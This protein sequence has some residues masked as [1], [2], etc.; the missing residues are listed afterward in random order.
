MVDGGLLNVGQYVLHPAAEYVLRHLLSLACG[1][2]SRLRGFLKAIV[3]ES[4]D[5]DNRTSHLAGE[6]VQIEFVPIL[7]ND[8]HHI[9]GD[10]HGNAQF[11]QLGSQI[12]I[13]F[14]IGTVHDVQNGIGTFS[15]KIVSCNHF[16][17]R[18]GGEGIDARQIGEDHVRVSLQLAFLFLHGNAGPVAHVLIGAGQGI[19]QRGFS[20]V[21]IACQSD[22]NCHRIILPVSGC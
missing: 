13:S 18:V 16:L 15:Q 9:D 1:R 2:D 19:K 14:G 5:F 3:F 7:A 10:H 6:G 11:H 8:I 21:G 12:Q 20:A 4:R 17:Q 22:T